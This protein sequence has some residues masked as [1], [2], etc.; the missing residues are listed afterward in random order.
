MLKRKNI[1][2]IGSLLLVAILFVSS[3]VV[4]VSF[5]KQEVNVVAASLDNEYVEF[6]TA[7]ITE[8]I[9]RDRDIYSEI[10]EE[11]SIKLR[12][13][14]NEYENAQLIMTAKQKIADYN[15]SISDLVNANDNTKKI[16][17]DNVDIYNQHYSYVSKNLNRNGMPTG[18]IPDMLVPF[19]NSRKFG[20]AKINEGDNQGL[21]FT[22]YIP[23]DTL[24]GI[25]NGKVTVTIKGSA[26]EVPVQI[27]VIDYT[28]SDER[29]AKSMFT[30]GYLE[31]GELYS[32][33]E[34][35]RT[36]WKFMSE[37]R[38]N[39]SS[40]KITGM[41]PEQWAEECYKQ[42]SSKV[43]NAINLPS[44]VGTY[45]GHSS[46]ITVES[47]TEY[48]SALVD[49]SIKYNY[50]LIDYVV[51]YNFWIDEPFYIKY[52]YRKIEL[53][54]LH[55]DQAIQNVYDT[56]NSRSDVDSEFKQELL[57]SI[58]LVPDLCTSYITD[59]RY[60]D[61][62]TAFM[63]KP[64]GFDTADERQL[65]KENTAKTGYK[66]WF[67]TCNDPQYPYPT[68]HLDASG[69]SPRSL[70]W[71]MADYDIE[72]YLAWMTTKYVMSTDTSGG[73]KMETF[74]E[75]GQRDHSG[76]VGDGLYI[77]PG[78]VWGL[79]NPIP[80]IRLQMFRDGYEEYEL[81]QNVYSVYEAAG[82]DA[83]DVLQMLYKNIYSNAKITESSEGFAYSREALLY[84]VESLNKG[85][86]ITSFDEIRDNFNVEFLLDEELVV[87]ESGETLS[88]VKNENGKNFY[89][90]TINKQEKTNFL[91]TV[92]G[93]VLV[94]IYLGEQ[95]KYYKVSSIINDVLDDYVASKE[96]VTQGDITALKV[97][98]TDGETGK[99]QIIY[100]E[101]SIINE[102]NKN[103]K[104]VS[105]TIYT[106]Q[107]VKVIV[108][109][110]YAG[111]RDPR[112]MQTIELKAGANEIK[113]TNFASINWTKEKYIENISFKLGDKGAGNQTIYFTDWTIVGGG[114]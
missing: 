94:D 22:F 48:L 105:F 37:Y 16:T 72:G 63:P 5:N 25:Y 38:I 39:P 112:A 81:L 98:T 78:K 100:I 29:T 21:Y 71:M 67:Y 69:T 35:Y 12:V 65:Y 75:S 95:I 32:T 61:V 47:I 23:K 91:L 85:L 96:L 76:S 18:D 11:A 33:P 26:Y 3:L 9:L 45:E 28:L 64:D 30:I 31:D 111:S 110:K 113:L 74:F 1:S 51:F 89:K 108:C 77:Y 34:V 82:Y 4:G 54:C 6:W 10:K 59:T 56:C 80:S 50:N 99:T 88:A 62:I 87:K 58:K 14:K 73:T 15:V 68:M 70:G 36:Y 49:V 13:V 24:S 107:D 114:K 93:K 79:S 2:K 40:L 106:E 53:N 8:K 27:E 97:V 41:T 42:V 46:V 60:E 92:D 20:Y 66:T 57:K 52:E 55:F 90:L 101:S 43:V 86:L 103:T 17:K 7:P 102:L 104:E 19:A 84:L 44:R 83:D 109:F